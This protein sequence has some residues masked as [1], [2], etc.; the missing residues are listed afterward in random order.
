MKLWPGGECPYA[1]LAPMRSGDTSKT[2]GA[3]ML[4]VTGMV[5]GAPRAPLA[6]TEIVAV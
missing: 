1:T 5:F 2:G 3:T 6:V 4:S